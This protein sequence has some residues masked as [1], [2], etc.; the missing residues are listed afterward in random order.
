MPTAANALQTPGTMLSEGPQ[1]MQMISGYWISQA[2]YTAAKLQIADL[3]ENG[4]LPIDQLAARAQANEDYLYRVLRALASVG[5]FEEI[6]NRTFQLTAKADLLRSQHPQSFKPMALLMGEEHYHA[7]GRLADGVKTGTQPFQAMYGMG[8]FEYFQQHPEVSEVF[9]GAMTAMVKNIHSAVIDHYDFSGINTLVDI[10]GGH[11]QLLALILNKYPHLKGILFDLPHVAQGAVEPLKA[12]GLADR[13]TIESGD[14]FQA[15]APGGD[16]YIMGH[17]IHD[18]D[19]ERSLT[20]LRNIHKVIA[21]NGKVLLVESVV[22]EGNKPGMAKFMDLNMLVMTGGRE[23]TEEEYRALFAQ[24]GFKLTRVI[25][26]PHSEHA[27]V[28][29]V[30]Q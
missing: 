11:G 5:I 9:N 3:L 16:A 2:I 1:L 23:R 21:D 12:A 13:C 24:A 27:I 30:K 20:I 22:P 14:F 6:P 4:P 15:V 28:E 10:G 19:D 29:A 18:W 25:S 8:V 26:G 7:W 17:I